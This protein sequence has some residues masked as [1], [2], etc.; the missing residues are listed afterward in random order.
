VG[1][2][3]YLVEEAMLETVERVARA[4][5]SSADESRIQTVIEN[6]VKTSKLTKPA[7]QNEVS[8]SPEPPKVEVEVVPQAVANPVMKPDM[9]T[10]NKYLTLGVKLIPVHDKGGVYPSWRTKKLGD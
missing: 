9:E 10:L 6:A 1:E 2:E 3:A 8:N 5:N 4:F 7:Q